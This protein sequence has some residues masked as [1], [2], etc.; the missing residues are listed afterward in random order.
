M[1]SFKCR[2]APTRIGVATVCAIVAACMLIVGG[3]ARGQEKGGPPPKETIFARKI[4][5]SAVEMNMEAMDT[6][7]AGEKIDIADIQEHADAVSIMLLAFPH[8]FPSS[9]NQWRD[10]DKDRDPAT[11]TYAS[12]AVWTNFADFY[13]QATAA[14]KLAL[15]I[16]RNKQVNEVK[17][18]VAQLWATCHGCHSTYLKTD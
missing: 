11:D 12:P 3:T 18:L 15:D 13:R 2:R 16:A 17:G 10:D 8:M 1:R 6:L 14:S 4:L 5:M 7:I 9:T